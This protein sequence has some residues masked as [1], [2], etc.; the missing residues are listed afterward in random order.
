M[1]R[2]RP[3]MLV[4]LVGVLS[5]R[6][7]AQ[8]S[9]Q[10][11]VTDSGVKT[12]T[13]GPGA[14]AHTIGLQRH[15]RTI[16]M[17]TGAQTFGLRYVVARDP[18]D[19]QAAIP[20]EGYIGMSQPSGCNWYAGGFFDLQVNG[21]SIGKTLTHAVTGRSSGSRGTADFIFDHS[22]AVVRVRFVARAGEDCLYAQASLEPKL[23]IKSLRLAVRC[24]P[25]A[26][27]S[28]AR[29]HV[30]T[31]TRDFEQ[32]Q[33]ADL[34]IASE[35]WTLYY[36]SIYDSGYVAPLRTGVG[37]CAVLWVPGQTQKAGF[38]VGSYGI[39]TLFQLKPDQRDFR[40]VFF[41]YAGEK[42]ATARVDL[43]GRA[44]SLL[45]ELRSFTFADP[46]L[47]Q[48]PLAQKQAEIQQVL[49]LLPPDKQLA[50]EYERR[51]RDLA[52]QLKLLH[53]GA[54]GSIKAEADAV[55]AIA[56][57]ESSLPALKLKALLNEI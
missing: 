14:P 45:K 9:L 7:P 10:V 3:I 30:L 12:A 41:D 11:L 36:D 52:A 5:G 27:V 46:T 55:Q 42:N 23:E 57:W 26:F 6:S 16:V 54:A 31:A 8:E 37:P 47:A 53:S 17:D 32:G 18:K 34:D 50:A 24:Y 40:F 38:T 56:D 51:S 20:G 21:Q 25:S 48:W 35:W 29:R 22:L 28:D 39:D 15:M 13:I 4:G 33:R 19:A 44:Q 49:K 2:L 43:R 1:K